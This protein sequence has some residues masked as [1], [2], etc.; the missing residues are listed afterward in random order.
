MV[1]TTHEIAIKCLNFLKKF[2]ENED[3]RCLIKDA[4]I[5]NG[6]YD[7]WVDVFRDEEDMLTR[8]KENEHKIIQREPLIVDYIDR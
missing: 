6:D 4:M 7:V 1:E 2:Y 8:F 5:L 3:A